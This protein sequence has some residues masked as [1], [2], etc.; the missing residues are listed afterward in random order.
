MKEMEE[1]KLKKGAE[2][3][4]ECKEFDECGMVLLALE[5][6]MVAK[7]TTLSGEVKD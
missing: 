7:V 2:F 1:M 3:Q 6:G 5:G 4:E